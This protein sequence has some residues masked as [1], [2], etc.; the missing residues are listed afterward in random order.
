MPVLFLLICGAIDFGRAYYTAI[1]V[2][3]AAHAGALYGAQNP[4]DISGM[5]TAANHDASDM[6]AIQSS[7]VH[8]CE[9][10]DGSSSVSSCTSTPSCPDNYVNYVAVTATYT[11]AP[12]IKYPGIPSQITLSSTSRLRVG[13]D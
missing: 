12:L 4:T 2:A 1:E 7:A 9:C 6:S 5:E 11:Y 3:S 8:G 13:G 10:A